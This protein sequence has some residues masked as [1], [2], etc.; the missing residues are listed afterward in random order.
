MAEAK[1]QLI[2]AAQAED[3]TVTVDENLLNALSE[4]ANAL[5]NGDIPFRERLESILAERKRRRKPSVEE[6]LETTRKL[7]ATLLRKRLSGRSFSSPFAVLQEL[8]SVV[9]DAMTRVIGEIAGA[10]R[11]EESVTGKLLE[12]LR[13]EAERGELERA[14]ATLEAAGFSVGRDVIDRYLAPEVDARALRR[15]LERA[16]SVEFQRMI[17]RRGNEVLLRRCRT[18]MREGRLTRH[19]YG[20]VE[21]AL[22]LLEEVDIPRDDLVRILE[23]L[24]SPYTERSLKEV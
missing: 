8:H 3:T 19:E 4:K 14:E 1:F 7:A 12:P 2:P 24:A 5:I 20:L 10:F 15:E 11:D 6:A 23:R 16:I 22:R 13:A 17:V 9:I 21:R 18:F